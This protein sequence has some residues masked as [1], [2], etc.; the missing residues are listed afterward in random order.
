MR[1]L[2]ILAIRVP[3][4]VVSPIRVVGPAVVHATAGRRSVEAA[5]TRIVQG[6]AP[7]GSIGVDGRQ[8]RGDFGD[9]GRSDGG[10]TGE[11]T[12]ETVAIERCT[13]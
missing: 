13:R 9:R 10:G 3:R 5:L 6:R 2:V 7:R 4:V 8:S 1:I 11:S 12:G